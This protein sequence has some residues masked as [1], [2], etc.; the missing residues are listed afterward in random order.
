M[1]GDLD[2][3]MTVEKPVIRSWMRTEGCP[4]DQA[5]R[6]L[7]QALSRQRNRFAFPNDFTEFARQLHSRLRAKH[8]KNSD[9][10]EALRALREIRVRAAPSWDNDAVEIMFWFIRHEEVSDFNGESWGNHLKRWLDLVPESGRF[11]PVHGA[12]A[13]LDDLTASEYVES[14]PLDLDHL[15]SR[16]V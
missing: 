13:T 16:D 6:Q 11:R 9:E 12:V 10:G 15:S 3:V 4:T 7:A 2:Q 5:K 8:G 1:V 14:D